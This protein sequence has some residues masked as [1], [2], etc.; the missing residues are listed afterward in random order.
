M[1]MNSRIYIACIFLV[2]LVTSA[3]TGK[4]SF[5]DSNTPKKVTPFI[6]PDSS[7]HNHSLKKWKLDFSDEFNDGKIDTLKWNIENTIRKRID[8]TLYA[9]TNQVEEKNGNMYIYYSKSKVSDTAYSVGRFNSHYKY[10]PTYG[11]IETRMHVV[12]P[13]GHQTAFWMMPEGD[14][15]KSSQPIDGTA[16]D[17]AEIDIVEGIKE[18]EYSLGLHWDGYIKPAHKSNGRPIKA[19]N[20]HETE[21]HIYGFEW[22]PTFLKFYFDGKVVAEMT[23]P[24]LIPHVAH[25][26]Y[27]SGSCF[28]QNNWVDGD[29]RNNPFIQKGNID[30]AYIDYVRVYKSN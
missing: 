9:D 26:I 6:L 3:Q 28:G 7:Q 2:P 22:T 16:N 19:I 30:K 27:F 21:Y 5:V 17:G 4:K 13:N 15:M 23:D 1:K 12:R 18:N 20:M 10:A 24:K 25:F 29:I 14:G 8:I 11:F